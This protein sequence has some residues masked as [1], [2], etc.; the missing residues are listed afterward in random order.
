MSVILETSKGDITVDL[1]PEDCPNTSRNFLK[2]C[3]IKYYNNCLF[4]NVQ[5]NFIAQTGDPTATGTGGESIYGKMYGEQARFFDDEIR[6]HLKHKKKGTLAMAGGGENLNAS[7]FYITTGAE[8]DSL[9]EKHTVFGEVAEGLDVLAAIND[10]LVD[11][12]GRPMQN[13]R[14]RHT[15]VLDD[16]FEDPPQLAELLPEMSPEPTFAADDDR[17]EDDWRPDQDARP[18]EEIEKANRENEA[19]N[20]AVV[21]EMIGDLPEAES[22]P[23]SNM[24]FICK[25]NQVTTEEDLEII[26]SRFGTITSCDIIKD[27][28]TG[29]SLCYAFLGYDNDKSCE[30]AYFKMNNV[31][32]DDRRI[33]VDFSQ[34]VYHLWKDFRKFGKA[35][36]AQSGKDANAHEGG[37]RANMELAGGRLELKAGAGGVAPGAQRGGKYNLLLSDDGAPADQSRPAKRPR[38]ASSRDGS[39]PATRPSNGHASNPRAGNRHEDGPLR[40]QRPHDSHGHNPAAG[41]NNSW[42]HAHQSRHDQDYEG[43]DPRNARD[44]GPYRSSQ[45]HKDSHRSSRDERGEQHEKHRSRHSGGERVSRHGAEGLN[46]RRDDQG[47]HRSD[48]D[49][50]SHRSGGDDSRHNRH[51]SRHRGH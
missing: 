23:P 34:S 39:P 40:A 22:K 18:V 44:N 28:K 49:H 2:L 20:R 32:I 4:H 50:R 43:Q 9:D 47:R 10:V 21:L 19:H 25:L 42:A 31:L 30:D 7:Q 26:F 1:Y 24:L 46:R 11:N 41:H 27:W 33:K 14:L 29:D 5:H 12:N 35:G 36:S 15:I 51:E 3:K 8:L 13:I 48:G 45:Y 6:P 17:L 38:H 16:P 37:Q